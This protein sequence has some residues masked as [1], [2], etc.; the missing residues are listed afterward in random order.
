[1]NCIRPRRPIINFLF[2]ILS[3]QPGFTLQYHLPLPH[4][5]VSNM[6]G[7]IGRGLVNLNTK[8]KTLIGYKRW[9]IGDLGWGF[10]TR[11]LVLY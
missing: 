4:H 6:I 5:P 1:M 11:H 3:K 2:P 10:R 9:K 7:S 8:L